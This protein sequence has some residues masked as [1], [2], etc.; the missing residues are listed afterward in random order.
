MRVESTVNPNVCACSSLKQLQGN[1]GNLSG[2]R[3]TALE[4]VDAVCT[5]N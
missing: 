3:Y 4:R 5:I 2:L 1:S